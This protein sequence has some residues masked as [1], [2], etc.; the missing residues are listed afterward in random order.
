VQVPCVG[1][2]SS[3]VESLRHSVQGARQ[4]IQI[5]RQVQHL[6][7]GKGIPCPTASSSETHAIG[8]GRR[9]FVDWGDGFDFLKYCSALFD[10]FADVV[11]GWNGRDV[12]SA[13]EGFA[14]LSKHTCKRADLAG[15][16]IDI[17]CGQRN[18]RAEVV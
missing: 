9:E 4:S 13:V 15:K 16:V 6:S 8:C 7:S 12:L 14:D 17:T 10:D 18:G 2:D 1:N 5:A 11:Q 3:S